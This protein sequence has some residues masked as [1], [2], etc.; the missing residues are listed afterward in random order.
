MVGLQDTYEGGMDVSL[1]SSNVAQTRFVSSISG[2]C[3]CFDIEQIQLISSKT[4]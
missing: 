3:N 1:A 2:S 4:S